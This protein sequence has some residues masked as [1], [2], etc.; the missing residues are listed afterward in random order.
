M[1]T[2]SLSQ[3][4]PGGCAKVSGIQPKPERGSGV[5]GE[6]M[7]GIAF[8]GDARFSDAAIEAT[9]DDLTPSLASWICPC[10]SLNAAGAALAIRLY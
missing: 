3:T 7:T 4:T 10:G 5:I 6:R 9:R 1:H 2:R 8:A